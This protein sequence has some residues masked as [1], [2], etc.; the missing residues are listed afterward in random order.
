MARTA[1]LVL[2]ALTTVAAACERTEQRADGGPLVSRACK[3]ALAPG[4]QR[5]DIDRMISEL[6]TRIRSEQRDSRRALE[7][8]GHYFVVKA[9][10]TNDPGGYHLAASAAECLESRY[11]G[12]LSALLVR[13]HALHQLHRFREAEAMAR[14]LVAKREF[15]LDYGLLGDVLMEQGQLAEAADAYQKMIDIKPFYQSYTRAAHIRWLKGDIEGA[16]DL[17]H[18][19]IRAA[20]PRDPESVAWAYTRLATYELQR[21]ELAPARDASD[22]ALAFQAEYAPALLTRGRVLLALGRAG[23]AVGDLRRAAA[24][25]PLPEYLWVLA[26]ALRLMGSEREAQ[27]VENDLRSRGAATDPRTLALFLAT[28]G[29]SAETA[30]ALTERE[31]RQRADIFTHDARA[32]ALA[33]AG[34]IDEAHTTMTR[35]LAENTQDARLFLHAGLIAAS[36]GRVAEARTWLAKAGALRSALLPSE[37]EMLRQHRI[38]PTRNDKGRGK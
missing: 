12:E 27:A 28:R 25:N 21:G 17:I 10:L 34:H 33:A 18:T 20:S 6:Q 24:A 5:G 15:V 4:A 36:A 38:G 19:A 29:E 8:L 23:D 35:A 16:V 7:Q 30:L 3:I 31:L 1:Y 9:R 13:G 32:W 37:V 26:D 14:T 11:P 2:A 22:A